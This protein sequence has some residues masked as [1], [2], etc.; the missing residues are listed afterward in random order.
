M[1]FC[2]SSFFVVVG[3]GESMYLLVT[4]ITERKEREKKVKLNNLKQIL[5]IF[6]IEQIRKTETDRSDPLYLPLSLY[7]CIRSLM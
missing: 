6:D 4:I 2:I 3:G 5:I 1:S 7:A